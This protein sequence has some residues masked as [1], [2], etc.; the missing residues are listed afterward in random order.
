VTKIIVNHQYGFDFNRSATDQVLSI[1]QILEKNGNLWNCF[2]TYI[3]QTNPT[4]Q[5]G[6]KCHISIHHTGVGALN[7]NIK[8]LLARF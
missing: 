4:I 3:V 8:A 5:L 1:Q 7:P 2:I 6:E